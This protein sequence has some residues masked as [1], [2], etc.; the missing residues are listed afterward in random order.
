MKL[1]NEHDLTQIGALII[2]KKQTL[3][4][5]ES[6]TSG[7]MQHA[8]GSIEDASQFYQGGITVYNI[9]QKHKHLS[10]EPIHALAVNCVS[11][12][13][14]EEMAL[15]VS[16]LFNSNWGIGIT[17]YASPTPDSGNKLFAYFSIA[18]NR[19]ILK[20]DKLSTSL[21][22]PFKVQVFYVTTILDEIKRLLNHDGS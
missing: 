10:V 18:F 6:V 16:N 19:E 17:G 2:S 20:S 13:V 1:F 14:S 9:G 4:V 3:A 15:E 7:L 22:D 21:K 12:K 5:A 8:F 11:K